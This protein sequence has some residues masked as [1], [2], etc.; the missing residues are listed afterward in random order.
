GLGLGGHLQKRLIEYAKSK[1]LRGFTA[2]V[3]SE[4]EKMLAVFEKGGFKV[5]SK[6]VEGTYEVV[7]LFE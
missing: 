3:L 7:M 5:S 6:V 1:G 2:D 4:N